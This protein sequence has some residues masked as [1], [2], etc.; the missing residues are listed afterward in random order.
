MKKI[1]FITLFFLLLSC[2]LMASHEF[3][4]FSYEMVI[5]EMPE[6]QQMKDSLARFQTAINAELQRME[7]DFNSKYEDFLEGQK[8]FPS[9]IR[10]KRQNE[11]QE[12]INRKVAFQLEMQQTYKEVEQSLASSIR[13][14]VNKVIQKIGSTHHYAFV[15]NTDGD[16]CPWMDPSQFIDVTSQILKALKSDN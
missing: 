13:Q 1:L 9:I 11:L 5:V 12:M 16:L 6:Y 7:N 3:A 10:Q 15:I 14:K 8:D 2:R 4:C